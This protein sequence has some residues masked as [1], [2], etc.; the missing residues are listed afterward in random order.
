MN[1]ARIALHIAADPPKNRTRTLAHAGYAREILAH[2]GFFLE[3]IERSCLPSCEPSAIQNPNAQRALEIQNPV[4][5]ILVGDAALAEEEAAAIG[6][7]I[8]G[9]G[10][11]I[12]VGSHSGAP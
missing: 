6:Q 11:L 2:A 1:I 12:G 3:E 5:L 7:W 8:E 9:G 4:V 10:F